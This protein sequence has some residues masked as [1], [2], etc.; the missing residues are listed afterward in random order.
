MPPARLWRVRLA[1][2]V[3]ALVL[4]LACTP[5]AAS[6]AHDVLDAADV[7]ELSRTRWPL[8]L[9][10]RNASWRGGVQC[11]LP[12]DADTTPAETDAPIAGA[13]EGEMG[14]AQQAPAASHAASST[15]AIAPAAPAAP[16]AP[17]AAAPAKSDRKEKQQR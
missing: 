13:A 4:A 6:S 7:V 17:S 8:P 16:H 5:A 2:F 15:P 12:G 1:R 10:I 9:W 11:A 3:S 14:A